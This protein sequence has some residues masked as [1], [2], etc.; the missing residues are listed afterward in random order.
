MS[1]KRLSYHRE[2]ATMENRYHSACPGRFA[3]RRIHQIRDGSL[4]P[5]KPGEPPV[6]TIDPRVADLPQWMLDSIHAVQTDL[7]RTGHYAGDADY[8]VGPVTEAAALKRGQ[9][10]ETRGDEI[11]VS[12]YV[13]GIGMESQVKVTLPGYGSTQYYR[14]VADHLLM[15]EELIVKPEQARQVIVVID[16]AQRS[17]ELGKSVDPAPWNI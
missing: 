8:L 12:S 7:K 16:A 4:P 13:S 9:E 11:S 1:N 2:R 15:G 3:I 10:W 5:L 6:T 14:N 17:A